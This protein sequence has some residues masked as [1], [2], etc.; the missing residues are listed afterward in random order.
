M[1]LEFV[2]LQDMVAGV[3][4]NIMFQKIICR[5]SNIYDLCV[6]QYYLQTLE[7]LVAVNLQ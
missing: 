3:F 1:I 7:I 2:I 5:K 6:F 4:S